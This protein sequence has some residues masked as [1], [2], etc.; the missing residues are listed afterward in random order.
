MSE[1]LS[2]VAT[3]ATNNESDAFKKDFLINNMRFSASVPTVLSPAARNH[4]EGAAGSVSEV[5]R[6]FI[7]GQAKIVHTTVGDVSKLAEMIAGDFVTSFSKYL[8]SEFPGLALLHTATAQSDAEVSYLVFELKPTRLFVLRLS[9]V[10]RG[11]QR[12][13][14]FCGTYVLQLPRKERVK[15]CRRKRN[16]RR[17][18][19]CCAVTDAKLASLQVSLFASIDYL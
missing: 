7:L 9:L 8:E 18:E 11:A 19:R 2:G 3:N 17:I 13:R 12:Y 6:N 16:V 14:V 15:Q 5:S 10:K 4:W 1:S